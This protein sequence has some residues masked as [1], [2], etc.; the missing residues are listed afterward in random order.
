[1]QASAG[2]RLL[3]VGLCVCGNNVDWIDRTRACQDADVL[4]YP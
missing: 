3:T 2:A 1:V 4:H